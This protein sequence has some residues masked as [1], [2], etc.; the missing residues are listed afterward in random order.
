MKIHEAFKQRDEEDKKEVAEG[1]RG[2]KIKIE[3][4]GEFGSKKECFGW[5]RK[6]KRKNSSS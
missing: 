5:L 1:Y 3:R 2:I 6:E 4:S